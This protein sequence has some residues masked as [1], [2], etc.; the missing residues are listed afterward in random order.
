MPTC[1]AGSTLVSVWL[2]QDGILHLSSTDKMLRQVSGTGDLGPL[3]VLG[4]ISSP[5]G[6]GIR[7]QMTRPVKP[8]TQLDPLVHLTDAVVPDPPYR[9]QFAALVDQLL[10]DAP[11]FSAGS[12]ELTRTF[13]QW[14]DMGPGFA[15]MTVKAPV[16]QDASNRVQQLQQLGRSGLEALNYLHQGQ[17]PPADW[18]STQLTLV[19]QAETPDSSFLK[20]PWMSSYRALILAAA[21]VGELKNADTHEWKQKIL[22]EAAQ[23]EPAQ[24]YTW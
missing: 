21:A 1:I 18:K 15:A 20:L 11:K 16:L 5:E 3:G 7:E 14:R 2:E 8:S 6:V 10:G 19:G 4:K 9:R 24:K 13:E 22:D 12:D 17:T 23:Q